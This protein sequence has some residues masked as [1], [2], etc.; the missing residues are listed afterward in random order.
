MEILPFESIK[1]KERNPFHI[2]IKKRDE[3]IYRLR[4]IKEVQ[5]GSKCEPN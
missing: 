5:T 4:E 3:G 2:I 1:Q